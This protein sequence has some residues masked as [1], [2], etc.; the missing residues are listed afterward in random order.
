MALLYFG[1]SALLGD[2]G[3]RYLKEDQTL[4]AAINY[5]IAI[6]FFIA[7]INEAWF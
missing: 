4:K 1:M 2:N 3:N 7:A 6:L 5:I